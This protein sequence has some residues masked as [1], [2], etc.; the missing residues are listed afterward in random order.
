MNTERNFK[1]YR[2]ALNEV[3]TNAPRIPYLGVF[4]TDLTFMDDS[5]PSLVEHKV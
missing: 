4:L 1:V 2:A 3:P 5:H